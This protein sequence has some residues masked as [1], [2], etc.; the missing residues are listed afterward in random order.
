V[1]NVGVASVVYMLPFGRGKALAN[2]LHG[3]ANFMIGG[4]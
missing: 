2:D 4:W 3:F 1:R